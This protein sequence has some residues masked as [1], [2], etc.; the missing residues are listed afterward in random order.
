MVGRRCH[1][2]GGHS[3]CEALD[4]HLRRRRT[5]TSGRMCP[6]DEEPLEE[7]AARREAGRPRTG[8][9]RAVPLGDSETRGG[10]V[11]PQAPRGVTEWDGHQ[12]V[13]AGVTED[14][15]SALE[16]T[17]QGTAGDAARVPLPC[18]SNLPPAPEPWRPTQIFRRPG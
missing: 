16:T 17:G 11:N 9:R 3:P 5:D 2:V 4:G 1:A 13:P 14:R 18:F 12:W 7:W 10:H 6:M 15:E 8:E